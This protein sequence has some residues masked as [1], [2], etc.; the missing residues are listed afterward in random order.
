MS[1]S[2]CLTA[3]FELRPSRRKA[4]VLEYVRSE[5]EKT[6][7]NIMRDSRP[8][9][10]E[11]SLLGKEHRE[12]RKNLLEEIY[13]QALLNC[14]HLAEPVAQS[15]AEDVLSA[16]KSFVELSIDG[17]QEP[18][19]PM[20]TDQEKI[21]YAKSLTEI[22]MAIDV[23]HE[24][25]WRDELSKENKAK[26]LR[27]FSLL[28]QRDCL[29]VC[30]KNGRLAVVLNIL[31]A[32]DQR[33]KEAII[34]EGKNATTN[35]AISK[36]SKRKTIIVVP[37]SCSKW[38]EGKFLHGKA[39]LKAAKI[40]REGDRWFMHANF[41]FLIPEITLSGNIVGVDRGV[42]YPIAASVIDNNGAVVDTLGAKGQ[43]I[44]HVIKAS[45][46]K[47][48]WQQRRRGYSSDVFANKIN[49][50]LH[51]L[52]NEIADIATSHR[53]QVVIE[54]LDG[55]KQ[56]ITVAR[57]HGARKNPY[58]KILKNAQLGKLEMILNYKLAMKGLPQFRDII[59]AGTSQT[60]PACGEK[61]KENRLTRDRFKCITCTYEQHA[62]LSASIIIARRGLMK[63][64][65]GVKLDD[66]H[67]NMV[68]SLNES[69]DTGL[70]PLTELVDG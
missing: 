19:Y 22:S 40:V 50:S 13:K 12:E 7:W 51:L 38:H 59:A 42:I 48:K 45:M 21:N 14:K 26:A 57:K 11:A 15:L 49:M 5:T 66:L 27:P 67:K 65:K 35:E 70:G 58:Q 16:V 10:T 41:Q 20:V 52:A 55:L 33:A 1:I 3:V 25:K 62:D 17:D 18:S 46:K 34:S 31:R 56:V 64:T 44:G 60:C 47:R 2:Q 37:L 68:T 24:N 9:A 69:G 8:N 43:E 39:S 28:R 29:I 4:A 23:E 61:A 53:A 32:T 54:K 63:I 30:D 6:F 36:K